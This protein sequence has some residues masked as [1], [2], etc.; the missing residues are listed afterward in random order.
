MEQF[1]CTLTKLGWKQFKSDP[2]L[3]KRWC[4]QDQCHIYLAHYVDD[5]Y[6][7]GASTER[8]DEAKA[9][10]GEIYDVTDQGRVTYALGIAVEW[11][12]EGIVLHQHGYVMK[13][14]HDH[15]PPLKKRDS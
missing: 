8:I 6:L 14:L 5:V 2:C 4:T 13:L 11:K 12:S 9:V 1:R 7:T 15:Q 10:I 3:Y